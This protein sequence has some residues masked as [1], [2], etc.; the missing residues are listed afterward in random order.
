[1]EL[2]EYKLRKTSYI[3][4]KSR[5]FEPFGSR[6]QQQHRPQVEHRNRKGNTAVCSEEH[7]IVTLLVQEIAG[8]VAAE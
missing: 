5:T 4:C 6:T 1:M 3:L 8:T 7:E 2:Q